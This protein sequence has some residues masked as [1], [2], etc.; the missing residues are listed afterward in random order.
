MAGSDG[1]DRPGEVRRRD[2]TAALFF[3]LIAVW[4]LDSLAR[5]VIERIYEIWDGQRLSPV[6]AAYHGYALYP[7]AGEGPPVG[8]TYG[9]MSVA[10]YLPAVAA[11]DPTWALLGAGVL[12]LVYIFGPVFALLVVA[13]G[14]GVGR[15]GAVA[16]GLLLFAVMARNPSL[17]YSMLSPVH[18]AVALGF[19]LLA[20]LPLLGREGI[21]RGHLALS[22][23]L[24][25]M[26]ALAKQNAVFLLPTLSLY[27]LVAFGPRVALG[28]VAMLGGIG[29]AFGLVLIR[30]YGASTL[31]YYLF[32]VQAG[33]PLELHR[34]PDLSYRLIA[35]G[36][37]PMLVIGSV[38]YL[39]S[40]GSGEGRPAGVSSHRL[41]RNPWA[42][43][44]LV[45]LGNLPIALMG[46]IKRGGDSNSLSYTLYY[47]AASAACLVG[48][49][50]ARGAGPSPEFGRRAV[51]ALAAVACAQWLTTQILT[52]QVPIAFEW[53]RLERRTAANPNRVAYDFAR[54]HPGSAYF[55][56]NTLAVLM[57]E[58]RLY[59][60]ED[61]ILYTPPPGAGPS[62]LRQQGMLPRSPDLV[63]FPPGFIAS[64]GQN[65]ALNQFP[66]HRRPVNVPGL[67]GF[68]VFAR[69]G[70]PG[71]APE[72]R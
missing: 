29:L 3:G 63:A 57:A 30:I 28:Y 62:Y 67:E 46:A 61:A 69:G 22:A 17:I 48:E 23:T 58:G 31:G 36:S 32:G 7:K 38:L 65:A 54:R 9:P 49:T 4:L 35:M 5:T 50:Q 44:L 42:L 20:C 59:A 12:T 8:Y 21:S 64:W 16:L 25:V 27:C 6:F 66:D 71:G 53:A 41:A 2:W 43:P 70:P 37:L 19:G 72:P 56:W 33:M 45:A 18:D 52:A 24:A 1:P 39:R 60:S 68:I 15:A 40:A 34:L 47:L 51:K 26:A 14:R 10:A 11:P 13:T 55:P